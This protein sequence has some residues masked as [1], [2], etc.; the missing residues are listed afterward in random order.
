MSI[1][2]LTID[3]ADSVGIRLRFNGVNNR[4]RKLGASRAIVVENARPVDSRP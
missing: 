1:I 2:G 4:L 3:M